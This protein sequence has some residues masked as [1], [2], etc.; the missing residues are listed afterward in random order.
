M[1]Q[2]VNSPAETGVVQSEGG[3]LQMRALA[4]A[5]SGKWRM[6]P[7]LLALAIV[8]IYFG[9]RTGVFLSFRNLSFL[10][11]QIVVTSMIGLALLFVLLLGEIDLA[12]VGTAAVAATVGASLA[13]DQDASV[14]VSLAAAIA[15]GALI[16]LVQGAV[17]IV[18]RSPS[19]IVSLGTS[20]VLS[21]VLLYLLP[22]TGLISLVNQPLANLTITYLPAWLG[23]VVALAGTLGI[24]LLRTHGYLDKRRHGLPASLVKD[25]VLVTAAVAVVAAAVVAVLNGYRGVPTPLAILLGLLVVA[26]YVTTQTSF[27]LHLYAIG[28]N[29]EAARRAGISVARVRLAAFVVTGMIAALGGIIA[30]GRILAV[31]TESASPTLL[32]EAIAATVIG[33]TSLFGGRGSVWSPLVG[34]LVVGS[35]ANGMLLLDASTESRLVVQGAILVLAVALDSMI[36]RWSEPGSR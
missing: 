9:A 11:V 28:T 15:T 17:V 6:A 14:A 33:G 16:G 10:S 19:F 2:T 20:L 23:Y 7:I 30:A 35:I 3:R 5:L 31:S 34:A 21:G 27:G 26:A 8:W 18:T 22:P 12:V 13:V 29:A 4:T 32:L 36:S 24:L 25:V 1:S